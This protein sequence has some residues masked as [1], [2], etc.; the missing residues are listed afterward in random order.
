MRRLMAATIECV[1]LLAT[2]RLTRRPDLS[3]EHLQRVGT[4]VRT[5]DSTLARPA[6]VHSVRST[7]L[8]WTRPSN[9]HGSA[10]V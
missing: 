4:A 3:L 1:S 10:R 6:A 7:A 2:N 9:G 5:T 8:S